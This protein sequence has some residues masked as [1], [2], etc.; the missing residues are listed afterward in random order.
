MEL[1]VTA[2]VERATDLIYYSASVA[3]LGSDAGSVTWQNAVDR[4][5][6]S[7]L[8]TADDQLQTAR[9]YFAE[10]GAW[11]QTEIDAWNAHEVNALLLQFIS[12]D[13]READSLGLLSDPAAYEREAERGTISGRLY[14]GDCGQWFFYVGN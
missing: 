14:F 8:I 11:E 4:S 12:G 13:I 3:E 10:F 7:P 1:N 2:L 6:E 5:E 9:D